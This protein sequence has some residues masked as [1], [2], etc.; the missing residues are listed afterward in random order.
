MTATPG[1]APW[2]GN[3]VCNRDLLPRS[4]FDQV[5]WQRAADFKGFTLSFDETPAPAT[6][7]QDA[8][9]RTEINGTSQGEF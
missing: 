6:V 2:T 8:Q 9:L 3:S 4:C 7:Y 5:S 1:K